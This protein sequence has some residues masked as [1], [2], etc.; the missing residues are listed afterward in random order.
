ME[1]HPHLSVQQAEDTLIDPIPKYIASKVIED[2]RAGKLLSDELA[3]SINAREYVDHLRSAVEGRDV[4]QL[5]SMFKN[6]SGASGVLA[7]TILKR[8]VREP[9]VEQFVRALWPTDAPF[10]RKVGIVSRLLDV[11][12]LEPK[13]HEELYEFVKQN[14]GS[15]LEWLTPWWGGT[16]MVLPVCLAR[17]KDKDFPASKHWL[18]LCGAL[19][20]PDKKAVADLLTEYRSSKNTFIARVAVEMLA[21][22]Q[23]ISPGQ[24]KSVNATD[25]AIANYLAS[26][27]I[28]DIRTGKQLSDGLAANLDASKYVVHLR[29]AVE[30]SD[31]A[32]LLNIIETQSEPFGLLALTMLKRHVNT[33]KVEMSLRELWRRET[34]F[35]TKVGVTFRLL[36]LD[37]L[38]PAMHEELYAF[39]KQNLQPF[40]EWLTWWS[41]GPD[42]VLPH[43][44]SRLKDQ[45][46]PTSKHWLFLCR[47]PGSSDREA[48]TV[49]LEK[50][51][52]SPDAFLARVATEM[53]AELQS[54]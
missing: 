20:A 43:C 15:F 44:L 34:R 18:Y 26:K 7:L 8:F 17:L 3:S 45:T 2:I 36:D 10:R 54:R 6:E 32:T 41:G 49:L 33:K 30:E 50:Y 37:H 38:E 22:L 19:G 21:E 47:L 42:R 11:N 24:A 40:L 29:N 39:I 51:R 23:G 12:T 35:R 28:E 31:V 25:G 52:S 48:V 13:L 4:D 46:F 53:L 27:V 14:L 9:R 5:M 16:D 1:P